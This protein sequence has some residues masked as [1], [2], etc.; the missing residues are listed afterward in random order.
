MKRKLRDELHREIALMAI[1]Y[2]LAR[3]IDLMDWLNETV[4][5]NQ[6]RGLDGKGYDFRQGE[7][8]LLAESD[9]DPRDY[10]LGIRWYGLYQLD[11]RY[12]FTVGYHHWHKRREIAAEIVPEVLSRYFRK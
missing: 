5:L 10:A 8:V 7:A 1:E 3:R 12:V 11:G 4:A 6:Y 9:P 2:D